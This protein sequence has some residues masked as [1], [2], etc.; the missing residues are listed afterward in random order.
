MRGR[1]PH[2]L[3]GGPFSVA[4]AAAAGVPARQLRSARFRSLGAGFHCWA[5]LPETPWLRL[6]A[7]RRRVPDA[8]FSGL[9]AAWLH[10][11][12]V[13]WPTP[14]EI[15]VPDVRVVTSRSGLR[16]RSVRLA[17]VDT[18]LIGG[19]PV[20]SVLRMIADLA[21]RLT[22]VEALVIADMALNK[23]LVSVAELDAYAASLSGKWGSARLRRIVASVEPLSES[24]ME[25]RIRY[26]I[27]E[28]G[29]ERPVAQFKAFGV[30]GDYLGKLDLS[31][32]DLLLGIEY[33]GGTHRES[34]VVDDQRQN[35]LIAAGWTILRFTW[36]DYYNHRRALVAHV[37]AAREAAR[38]R[39]FHVD[40]RLA[41]G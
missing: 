12:D 27:V 34:L 16:V 2:E 13:D 33:D 1:V 4:E 3:R 9:T 6:D 40:S 11:L 41:A 36:D 5:G 17:P 14:I 22:T 38:R 35:R 31:Y 18:T 28:A 24:P 7:V 39:R 37:R 23:S 19:R 10:G 25:S 30:D 15:S 20:T 26:C 32:P 8:V 29:L 21:H